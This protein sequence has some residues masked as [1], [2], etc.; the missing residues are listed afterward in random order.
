MCLTHSW[1]LSNI[2]FFSN[3]IVTNSIGFGLYYYYPDQ[4]NKILQFIKSFPE[5]GNYLYFFLCL[6]FVLQL[7][8]SC[9]KHI[10]DLPWSLSNVNGIVSYFVILLHCFCSETKTISDLM[11]W[12]CVPVTTAAATFRAIIKPNYNI[13]NLVNLSLTRE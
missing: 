1:R 6:T 9:R 10:R 12:A 11:S 8:V 4:K 5:K 7:L 3:K 2:I 13:F